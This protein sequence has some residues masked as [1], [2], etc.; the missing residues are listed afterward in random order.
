LSSARQK[1]K[2]WELR[3]NDLMMGDLMLSFAPILVRSS[4]MIMLAVCAALGTSAKAATF[5][6]S[7]DGTL[8]EDNNNGPSLVAYGGGTLGTTGYYFKQ[9]QGLS[10]SGTGLFDAYSIDI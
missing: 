3:L 1:S 7:L 9:N 8:A 10:L 5:T 4:L 2:G 6:Y